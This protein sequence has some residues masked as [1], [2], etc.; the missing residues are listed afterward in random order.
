MTPSDAAFFGEQRSRVEFPLTHWTVVLTAANPAA[1][2]SDEA[3]EELCRAYWR[4]VY[5]FVRQQGHGGG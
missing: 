2:L 1:P 3:L 5:Q 4:P